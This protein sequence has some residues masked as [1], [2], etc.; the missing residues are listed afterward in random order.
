MIDID[1]FKRFNDNYGHE[2]GNHVLVKLTGVIKKCIR[3]VDFLC[4]YGGEEFIVILPQTPERE[5]YK[6]AERIR[7]EVEK[8]EFG[9]GDGIPVLKVTVSVGVS[10]FPENRRSEEELINA[11][12]Q[13]LY[14]AKGSGKN[15]VCTV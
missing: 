7:G 14:R 3:D 9:G 2:V 12:D 13:A 11:V 8:A 5:A 10:S 1:W 15:T 4:R 6:I